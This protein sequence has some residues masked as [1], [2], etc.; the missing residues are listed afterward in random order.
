[1]A[2]ALP[3][4][5]PGLLRFA[6]TLAGQGMDA[7]DLVQETVSRALARADGFREDASLA[8]WLHRILHN[9]VVDQ[10]R[11]RHEEPVE[12]LTEAV[13]SRWRDD[14]YTVDL[15][16]VLSR[17]EERADLLDALSHLPF[18]YRTAVVLHDAE[19][20]SV[21][22]IADIQEVSLP[23]A[24]Q[25]LR[26][27]RMMLVSELAKGHERQERRPGVPMRCW[28]ARREIGD[29]ID[30]DLDPGTARRLERHLEGCPTCPA[31]YAGLVGTAE[32]LRVSAERDP[33]TVVPPD[34]L[35]RLLG[36]QRHR[37]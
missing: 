27:G 14:S 29:Y 4:Q 23:A 17:A 13:E 25:R 16:V 6:R 30:G 3:D 26:R 12:D 7:E 9:L 28:E 37:A 36:G 11:R 22:E 33:D 35:D 8:T 34:V 20:M 1:M 15:S 24:K 21:R 10:A 31:L 19:G 18:G 32:A 2:A 5:L